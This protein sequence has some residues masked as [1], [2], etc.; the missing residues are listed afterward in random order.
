MPEF[1]IVSL[2]RPGL[3]GAD[4][5]FRLYDGDTEN[6][7]ELAG[8]TL[9]YEGGVDYKIAH[10]PTAGNLRRRITWDV[11]GQGGAVEWPDASVPE[12]F[13][14]PL[15][16]GGLTAG[17]ITLRAFRDGEPDG[18]VSMMEI[19]S[20]GD[21]LV[22]GWP[23]HDGGARW[24]V[25]W[26][27]GGV[28]GQKSWRSLETPQNA[29]IADFE[30]T[31]YRAFADF[32]GGFRPI[33]L[34]TATTGI[35]GSGW[36][37]IFKETQ[38]ISPKPQVSGRPSQPTIYGRYSF[39]HLWTA[40]TIEGSLAPARG[41]NLSTAIRLELGADE[42]WVRGSGGVY[43]Q[44]RQRML[45]VSRPDGMAIFPE[46]VTERHGQDG[47]FAVYVLRTRFVATN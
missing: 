22:S 34:P 9:G 4:L 37:G 12:S 40:A 6:P 7:S 41:G 36:R 46:G 47:D 24:V 18:R 8:V 45:E 31:D 25:L 19:G 1:A 39:D 21:Y 2:P 11:D 5:G 14:I 44:L 28:T 23:V 43:Q 15:R 26:D 13:V 29:G 17:D 38:Y 27:I 30:A 32:F 33:G 20:P 10:L 35:E 3:T 42:S 16:V